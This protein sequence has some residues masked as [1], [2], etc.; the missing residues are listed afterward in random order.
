MANIHS[1]CLWKS[2][3]FHWFAPIWTKAFLRITH[4]SDSFQ[5]DHF[6]QFS[7]FHV[8]GYHALSILIETFT[9]LLCPY[10][11]MGFKCIIKDIQFT[12]KR[13]SIFLSWQGCIW[14]KL[15]LHLLDVVS[16]TG[17]VFVRFWATMMQNGT[18]QHIPSQQCQQVL[19]LL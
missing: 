8:F 13:K 6:L 16:S 4:N 19:S 11:S 15:L 7:S 17:W 18:G 10:G 9:Y 12:I 3:C 2:V 14:G 5:K 1:F